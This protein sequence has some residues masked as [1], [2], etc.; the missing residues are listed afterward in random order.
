MSVILSNHISPLTMWYG[1]V[2]L[3]LV[4]ICLTMANVMDEKHFVQ[5]NFKEKIGL[6]GV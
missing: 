4:G 2:N 5:R 3:D 6:L 1:L